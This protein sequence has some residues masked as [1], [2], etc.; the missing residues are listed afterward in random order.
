MFAKSEF[1]IFLI[2]A[3]FLLTVGYKLAPFFGY[4]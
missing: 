3:L 4:N 2:V 1:F